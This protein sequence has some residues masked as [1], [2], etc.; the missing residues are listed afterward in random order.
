MRKK[1]IRTALFLILVALL[2]GSANHVLGSSGDATGRQ[3]IR[4]FYH[5]PKDSVDAVYI[6][7]SDVFM[8]FQPPLAWRNHGIAVWNFA[9]NAQ[10]FAAAEDLIREASKRQTNALYIVSMASA[11]RNSSE[12]KWIHTLTD[13][14]PLSANKLRL[15]P[16]LAA[17]TN[18]KGEEWLEFYFPVVRFH[19]RW[20]ELTEEDFHFVSNGLKGGIANQGNLCTVENVTETWVMTE[21]RQSAEPAVVEQVEHLLD[22]CDKSGLKFLFVT[23]PM[24]KTPEIWAQLNTLCDMVAARGYPVLRLE[25]Q[26]D[27]YALDTDGDFYNTGHVNIHGSVKYTDYLCRYLAENYG[28]TDHRKQPGYEAWD[29]AAERY[30]RKIAPYVLPFELEA[31]PRTLS[32]PAVETE[33]SGTDL[34][35]TPVAE[36]DGYGVFLYKADGSWELAADLDGHSFC[37][38]CPAEDSTVLVVAYQEHDGVRY[39]GRFDTTV[40][41]QKP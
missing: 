15:I 27:E 41:A 29:A 14:L 36:A 37:W 33:R 5:E 28:F 39:W 9:S 20:N 34:A 31:A 19:A 12:A 4:G 30:S 13:Y 6:G 38:S 23:P 25:S 10:P 11:Y 3:L 21:E 26:T 7:G 24:T 18:L 2:L 32:L 35:W 1:L 16:K 8:F 22:Y 17:M 40:T